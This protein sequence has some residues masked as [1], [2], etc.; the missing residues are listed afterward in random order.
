MREQYSRIISQIINF[1][2]IAIIFIVPLLFIPLP[3]NANDARVFTEFNK[4]LLFIFGSLALFSLWTFKMVLEK[5]VTII[6]TPIDIPLIAFLLIY[7]LSTIFSIDPF[8]SVA[9]YYG[10]FHPSLLG[11]FALV[12]FYFTAVSNLNRR[13]RALALWSMVASIVLLSIINIFNFFGLHTI[14][15]KIAQT[16]DWIPILSL[17]TLSFIN[18]LVI[19]VSVGLALSSKILWQRVLGFGFAIILLIPILII[20]VLG[21]WL[22]LIAALA[23]FLIFA[24]NVLQDKETRL[25]ILI[26]SGIAII[27]AIIFLTPAL[28]D[29]IVKPLINGENKSKNLQAEPA[30]SLDSGWKIAANAA[31]KRPFLGSGPATFPF[32]FTRYSPLSLNQ[33]QNWN[34]RFEQASNEYINLISTVGFAGLALFLIILFLILRPLFQFVSKSSTIR[35]NPLLLLLLSSLSGFVVGSLFFDTSLIIGIFLM[36]LAVSIFGALFDFGAKGVE[37]INLKLV[38]LNSGAIKTFSDEKEGTNNTLGFAL[39]IPSTVV[40]A[41]LAYFG[42]QAYR[43]EVF[44]Q[45]ALQKASENKGLETRD[46]LEKAT[47]TFPHRDIYHRTLSI[48]DLKLAVNLSSQE[49]NEQNKKNLETL[50]SQ[51]VSEGKI[52]SGYQT[53]RTWGTS[54]ENVVNWESLST[55]YTSLVGSVKGADDNTIRTYSMAIEKFPRNP[56]FYEALAGVYLKINQTENAIRAAERAVTLKPDLASPHYTLA[57]AYRKKE[58]RGQDAAIQ[59]QVALNLLPE[60]SDK[61]RVKS[62][63]EELKKGLKTKPSETTSSAKP[64]P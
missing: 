38:S 63:L 23:T 22:A 4:G 54:S 47:N 36:L 58:D 62:E 1:G 9:G 60:G 19:P 13:T 32:V 16:R 43:A 2:I 6:R 57:Q 41:L 3:Q 35:E 45:K 8:V 46:L 50:L 61:D 34:V 48:V 42:T 24:P 14:P 59:L 37:K 64:N 15:Y 28:S 51:A 55:V 7:A 27:L 26:A 21:A 25:H 49:A 5:K 29:N 30:L 11:V 40:M 20:N 44:Y 39:L 33:T 18:A 10:I 52:A 53:P 12:L 17:G 31:S 56:L